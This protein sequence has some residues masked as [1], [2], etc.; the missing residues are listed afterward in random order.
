MNWKYVHSVWA[1]VWHP[2]KTRAG[3][4]TLCTV[5]PVLQAIG[6]V[7]LFSIS[8]ASLLLLSLDVRTKCAAVH[9]D[10]MKDPITGFATD[11]R[12][13]SFVVEDN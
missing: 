12:T 13:E 6:I 2:R 1:L 11:T 10:N 3:A 8:I 5:I 4:Q 9:M 7:L